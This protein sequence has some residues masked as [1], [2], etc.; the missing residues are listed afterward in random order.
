PVVGD[1]F[2]LHPRR[3]DKEPPAVVALLIAYSPRPGGHF[4]QG[5]F[6]LTKM[7]VIVG[8]LPSLPPQNAPP[9]A[10]KKR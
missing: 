8:Y 10:Y 2:G 9:L 5:I 1:G 4:R 6:L 7:F 3:Q